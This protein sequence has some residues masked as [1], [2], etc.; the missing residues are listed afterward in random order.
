MPAVFAMIFVFYPNA[1][2]IASGLSSE[3]EFTAAH[4]KITLRARTDIL[5]LLVYQSGVTERTKV[6]PV[7]FFCWF[8]RERL[9]FLLQSSLRVVSLRR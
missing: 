3:V 5:A 6:P 2:K 1:L 8:C 9:S 4:E 7:F